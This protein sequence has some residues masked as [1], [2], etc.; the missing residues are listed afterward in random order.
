[1]NVTPETSP[2]QEQRGRAV[3]DQLIEQ[4]RRGPL[5]FVRIARSA[6]SHRNRL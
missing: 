3:W 5:P 4:C 6:P 2:G 1:M